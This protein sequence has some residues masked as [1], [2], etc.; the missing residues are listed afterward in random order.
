MRIGLFSDFYLP[1]INGISFVLEITHEQLTALGH[2]V[3]IFAPATNLKAKEL[4]DPPY[5]YRFPAIE[6]MFFDEQLTSVF[7]PP[8]A[9]LK[10]KRLHLD[11]IH[12]FTPAQVGLLGIY[13]AIRDDIPLVAQYSTDLYQYVEKYPR[14]LPGT[15][16]LS[17][18]APF[19][20]RLTPRE[21]VRL[22]SVLRPK[23][24][25]T[26][27]HK[28]VIARMHIALHD[29]SDAVIALSP[30]M[31]KQLD[32]WGGKTKT[33]LLPTGVDALSPG[34]ASE[35][36]AFKKD[37]GINPS[38]NLLLYAGR[39]SREKNLELL[40]DMFARLEAADNTTLVLAGSIHSPDLVEKAKN[41]PY[42]DKII[43]TGKY[44]RSYA[45][46]I[47]AAADIFLFPSLTDT[48]GLVVNEAAAAGL[49]LVLCDPDFS[50]VFIDNKTGLLA[51]SHSVGFA[52]TVDR[53]IGDSA[54]CDRLAAQ[55]QKT[56]KSYSERDQVKKLV[57]LYVKSIRNHKPRSS[58]FTPR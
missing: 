55:A 1:N 6:G 28:N 54:L 27:W 8:A 35:V 41:S 17:L 32:A 52:R 57:K 25:L 20:L 14:V 4:N 39:V 36:A 40:V 18:V 5:V 12:F 46:T 37:Y 48:Q 13:T 9:Y 42:A 51:S 58:F 34:T 19:I 30:K 16:A 31:K 24:S 50:E 26:A 44:D 23:R 7:F 33:T 21:T 43:F 47:Y 49:P 11:I 10:I 29:R 15:I 3:Y 45:G 2:E 53:L 22:M 38:D 56:A